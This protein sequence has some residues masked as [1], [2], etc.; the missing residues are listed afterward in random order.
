MPLQRGFLDEM[1]QWLA[2][3]F[4]AQRRFTSFE[5]TIFFGVPG[6]PL[7]TLSETE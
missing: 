3:L 5:G 2:R 7:D 4:K 6:T 1:S